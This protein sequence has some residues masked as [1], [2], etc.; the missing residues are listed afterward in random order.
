[1]NAELF[2]AFAPRHPPTPQTFEEVDA[3]NEAWR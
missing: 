1:M 3:K 2:I